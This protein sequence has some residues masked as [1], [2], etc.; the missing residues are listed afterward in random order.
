MH[1]P[2]GASHFVS[3]VCQVFVSV[4]EEA[5]KQNRLENRKKKR[6]DEKKRKLVFSF[7]LLSWLALYLLT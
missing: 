3:L 1:P 6:R 4:K 7:K 2:C 5:E